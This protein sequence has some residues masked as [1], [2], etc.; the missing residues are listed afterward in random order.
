MQEINDK[1]SYS[2][3]FEMIKDKKVSTYALLR[4]G[5]S[6][7]TYHR[8]KTGGN[9]NTE[10][11]RRLCRLLDCTISDVIEYIP[12]GTIVEENKSQSD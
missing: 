5:I 8:L 10:T 7:T 3:F 6:S 11:L 2:P 1:I 9:V 4:A 12:D